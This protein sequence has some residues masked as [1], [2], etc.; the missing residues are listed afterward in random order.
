MKKKYAFFFVFFMF[1]VFLSTQSC[2]KDSN[3]D[4]NNILPQF[5]GDVEVA[6]KLKNAATPY[7]EGATVKAYVSEAAKKTDQ[8]V[9]KGQTDA[10]GICTL[11]ELPVGDI[12]IVAEASEGIIEYTG[13]EKLAILKN[14]VVQSTVVMKEVIDPNNGHLEVYVRRASEIGPIM[15]D[16]TVNLYLSEQ[17]RSDDIIYKQELTVNYGPT[18][19]DTY[20][21]FF[22][23]PFHTY[24]L[25]AILVSSGETYIGTG[26]KQVPKNF[27]SQYYLVV[28][29]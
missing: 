24:Y 3:N 26:T 14:D 29:K 8:Y 1:F 13:E 4:D 28:V 9:K 19:D 7:T 2:K 22:S 18:A 17:D 16:A 21:A 12:I 6:V 5:F 25:K 15:S 11:E 20:A 10:Q 27:T 23:L